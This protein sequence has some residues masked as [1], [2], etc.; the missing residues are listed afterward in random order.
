M[1]DPEKLNKNLRRV[2]MSVQGI[3]IILVFVFFAYLMVTQKM[4][5]LLALPSMA[6]VIAIIAGMPL[7]YIFSNIIGA[8]AV[9]LQGAMAAAIFGAILAQIINKTGISDNIVRT[10]AEL[11]GDR[12]IAVA[13]AITFAVALIFT[14]LGG[15]GSVIMVGTIVLPIL[16]SV[17]IEPVIAASL[18]LMGL[19][20]GGLF[21]VMNYAFYQSALNLDMATIKSFALAFGIIAAVVLLLF[22]FINVPKKKTVAAWA[23]STETHEE[24][25]RVSWYALLTPIIPVLL[26]FIWPLIFKDAEG[27]PIQIDIISAM[28][29]G[30]LYGILTTKPRE[31]KNLLTSSIIEGIKDVAPAL[32]LMI[33]IGMLL[34]AVMDKTTAAL[35]SP[36]ISKIL[37]TSKIGYVLFFIILSPLALY[38]GPLNLWGL[39]SGV[40]ALMI[41]AGTLPPQ[42]IMGALIATGNIQGVCD[43]TNTH[44]VWTAYFTNTD[45]TTILKKTLPYMLIVVLLDIIYVALF[46]W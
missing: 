17:G 8:G 7:N 40:A 14:S 41:S 9:R 11:G 29:I 2:F 42:A 28:L 46:K 10:A 33:G 3:L 32:G 34:L 45:T 15:L 31:I 20:L 12:P 43:P 5:A 22:I 4:P 13:L 36:I 44:N 37:P 16:M 35:I 19:N 1:R 27:K 30:I 6:I 23:M 26:L 39:G 24:K 38:R 21:N 18:L 25:P